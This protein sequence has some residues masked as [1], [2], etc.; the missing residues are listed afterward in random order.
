MKASFKVLNVFRKV[1]TSFPSIT[2]VYN[3]TRIT[4]LIPP[5]CTPFACPIASL[6]PLRSCQYS[7]ANISYHSNAWNAI[8]NVRWLCAV[9]LHYSLVE[10]IVIWYF[11]NHL[12]RMSFMPPSPKSVRARSLSL[13]A[14]CLFARSGASMCD[15]NKR[16]AIIQMKMYETIGRGKY[17]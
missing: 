16:W 11:S 1:V 14:S 8:E 13:P 4:H 15:Y 12:C 7:A 9:S 6:D 2:T 3:L 10:C 5:Q 17:F